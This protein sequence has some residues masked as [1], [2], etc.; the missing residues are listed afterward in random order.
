[1]QY[2][3]MRLLGEVYGLIGLSLAV[4]ISESADAIFVFILYRKNNHISHKK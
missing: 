2:I 1:L 4:L 3:V